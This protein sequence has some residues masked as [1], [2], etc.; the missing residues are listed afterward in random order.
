MFV[1][2]KVIENDRKTANSLL[3]FIFC[4]I[5]T[6]SWKH[7]KDN[8]IAMNAASTFAHEMGHTF[9]MEHD[10]DECECPKD[11]ECIM[12]TSTSYV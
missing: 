2:A 6:Y 11:N 8:T 4:Y 7:Y 9:G 12:A 5:T 1:F 10:A 3:N